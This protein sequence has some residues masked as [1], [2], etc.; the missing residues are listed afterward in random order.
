M[1]CLWS[2]LSIRVKG[3]ND[4]LIVIIGWGPDLDRL[5]ARVAARSLDDWV[6]F[7][8]ALYGDDLQA[9]FATG[10]VA[11]APDP[12]NIFND[13][14]TMV[15]IFEYMAYG[16]PVVLYELPEGRRSAGGAALYAHGDNPIDFAEKVAHLL[17][18]E[19]SRKQLGAIGRKQ[20][21]ERLNWGIEREMSLKAYHAA[22][23]G[24]FPS[25]SG[26]R[27]GCISSPSSRN[28]KAKT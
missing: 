27:S 28:F 24:Y 9:Y 10:D 17:D 11:V 15:K 8:G 5:K 14:L 21:V 4:A 6:K 18:S 2:P 13:K 16:M 19:S 1:I 22:F 20:I 7:T 25:L 23:N 26:T 12:S 3:R